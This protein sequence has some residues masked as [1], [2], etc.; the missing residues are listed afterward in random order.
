MA[1]AGRPVERERRGG[2]RV[3][4]KRI[5]HFGRA[6]GGGGLGVGDGTVTLVLIGLIVVLVGYVGSSGKDVQP[7][8]ALEARV[9]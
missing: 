4:G 8:E 7:H 5:R 2:P 3:G 6:S 1:R 9:G